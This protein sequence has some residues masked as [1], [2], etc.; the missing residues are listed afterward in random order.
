ML[1][2]SNGCVLLGKLLSD[3]ERCH[4]EIEIVRLTSYGYWEDLMR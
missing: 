1:L 3:S 4:Y 2:I